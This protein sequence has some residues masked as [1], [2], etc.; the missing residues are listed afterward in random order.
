MGAITHTHTRG[1]LIFIYPLIGVIYFYRV[2]S[3]ECVFMCVCL[4]GWKRFAKR[5]YCSYALFISTLGHGEHFRSRRR[6][7]PPAPRY[8][9]RNARTQSLPRG[10]TF[11]AG[12]STSLSVS[13]SLLTVPVTAI[14]GVSANTTIDCLCTRILRLESSP[15]NELGIQRVPFKLFS[16]SQC[17]DYNSNDWIWSGGCVLLSAFEASEHGRCDAGRQRPLLPCLSTQFNKMY[18]AQ[19]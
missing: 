9:P 17:T 2:P 5:S 7:Q 3:S 18:T 13:L 11:F 12:P 4:C 19:L 10:I 15:R 1:R 16:L 14:R 6:T 8:M